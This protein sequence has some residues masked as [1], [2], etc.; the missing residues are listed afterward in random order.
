MQ[1]ERPMKHIYAVYDKNDEFIVVGTVKEC[2]ECLG[3]ACSTFYSTRYK[4]NKNKR[5]RV[6]KYKIVRVE[7]DELWE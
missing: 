6:Y 1:G 7:D 3:I 4:D 2:C 5:K